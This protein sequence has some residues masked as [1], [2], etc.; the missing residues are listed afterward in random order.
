ML[1]WAGIATALSFA[2][3]F[4]ARYIPSPAS[5]CKRM[6][7]D[8]KNSHSLPRFLRNTLQLPH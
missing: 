3:F 5:I 8:L 7:M 6:S 1:N 2:S 4:D